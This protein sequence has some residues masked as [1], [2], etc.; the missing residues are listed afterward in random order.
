MDFSKTNKLLLEN[1]SDTLRI[2]TLLQEALGAKNVDILYY[3]KEKKMYFD[4][5]NDIR[6]EEKYIN[7]SSLL[8]TAILAQKSC[9]Y[10]DFTENNTQYNI[11]I[12]NPF[13]VPLSNQIIIPILKDNKPQG[14]LRFSQLP[15]SFT[16]HDCQSLYILLPAFRKIFSDEQYVNNEKKGDLS[17]MR[18]IN[19]SLINLE[20]AFMTLSRHTSN[21][22]I[23]KLIAMG[24]KN[25]ESLEDY[26]H[27]H[28]SNKLKIEEKL[29]ILKRKSQKLKVRKKL[30]A[31]V[32]I[33][34]D[35]RINVKILNAMLRDSAIIDQ[36]KYAYDGIETMDIIDKCREANESIH[37]L[38]L[39]HH[40][41]GK[42]GLEIAE[43]LKEVADDATIIIVSITNDPDVIAS[44]D[45]LY[46][47]HIPKP[48]NKE[49]IQ[50][51]MEKIRVEHLN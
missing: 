15:T 43:S 13:K 48:F 47:Y 29:K 33:A 4:K 36:I 51:V 14:I 18:L 41:P 10:N 19:E 31:N 2:H 25:V 50:R 37:I 35:V 23:Q 6:I 49:S 3:D 38:F 8:G 11:A 27:I 40:M 20:N 17:S 30:Y 42:T 39:D 16:R 12:D 9:F 5:I 26:F 44:K 7:S 45:Y 24:H 32:L 22:E 1:S 21:P 34:D 28:H 46:D